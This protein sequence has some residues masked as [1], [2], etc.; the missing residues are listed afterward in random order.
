L[1]FVLGILASQLSMA[2]MAG[3]L[4][5]R[6]NYEFSSWQWHGSEWYLLAASVGIGF[7]AAVLPALMAYNTDIHENLSDA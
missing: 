2:A 4:A 7:Q 1:G 3:S 6:Y 5:D